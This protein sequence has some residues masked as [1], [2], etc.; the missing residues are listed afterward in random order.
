MNFL[1]FLFTSQFT[2]F[3]ILYI[4]EQHLHLQNIASDSEVVGWYVKGSRDGGQDWK[5]YDISCGL[6]WRGDSRIL[7]WCLQHMPWGFLCKRSFNGNILLC[8]SLFKQVGF[9][10]KTYAYLF[11]LLLFRSLLASMSFTCS[12]FLNG[13]S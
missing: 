1:F 6:R 8:V 4:Q 12:A 2:L 11:S 13:T 7:W 3:T 9:I 5:S 10:W